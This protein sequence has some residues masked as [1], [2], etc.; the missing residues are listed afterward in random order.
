VTDSVRP[1][2]PRHRAAIVRGRKR[3]HDHDLSHKREVNRNEVDPRRL[4]RRIVLRLTVV[5]Q[6][7]RRIV[8][9]RDRAGL[10]RSR[11]VRSR[12]VKR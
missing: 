3:N 6:L 4:H 2:R 10:P 12:R 1:Q 11:R 5:R 9:L 7:H 8:P